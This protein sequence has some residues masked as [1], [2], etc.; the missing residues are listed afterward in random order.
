MLPE[1]ERVACQ[2]LMVVD[3]PAPFGPR[4]PKNWPAATWRSM[5]STAV[6]VFRRSA[7]VL[8]LNGNLRHRVSLLKV[9]RQQQNL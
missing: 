6:E 8:G 5:A 9:E 2:H 4:K 7:S 1:V 3:F